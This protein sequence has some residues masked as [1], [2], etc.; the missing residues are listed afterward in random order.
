ME[1]VNDPCGDAT[2]RYGEDGDKLPETQ[3]VVTTLCGE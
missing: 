2:D 3:S 1:D